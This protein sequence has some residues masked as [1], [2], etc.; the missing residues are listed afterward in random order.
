MKSKTKPYNLFLIV[1]LIFSS[2][3]YFFSN[4][5]NSID[6]HLHDTYF[7]IAYTQVIWLL[8]LIAITIWILYVITNKFLYSIKLVWVHTIS[9]IVALT[10][11]AIT[12]WL[13]KHNNGITRQY[14]DISNNNINTFD[15]YEKII[16][17]VLVL[18]V[19]VQIVFIVNF[20]IGLIKLG[21]KIS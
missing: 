8:A 1:A 11:I 13:L 19:V 9:T 20:I 3:V 5:N 15:G 14:Y 16:G 12:L 2:S 7:V 4:K 10:L 18:L 17:I 6:I 21:K